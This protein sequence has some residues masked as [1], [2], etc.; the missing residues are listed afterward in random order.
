MT[1]FEIYIWRWFEIEA[2]N[3]TNKKTIMKD[4]EKALYHNQLISWWN[5][6]GRYQLF[7]HFQGFGHRSAVCFW[8]ADQAI[9]V[10]LTDRDSSAFTI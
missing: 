3:K 9:T 4:I 5:W 2:K 10:A 7:K 1:M 6:L 8:C